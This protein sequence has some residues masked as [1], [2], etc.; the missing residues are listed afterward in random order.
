MTR[1][2]DKQPF[3]WAASS[4]SRT[5]SDDKKRSKDKNI[6]N[7]SVNDDFINQM[8]VLLFD[9]HSALLPINC[10]LLREIAVPLLL[11]KTN[12]T[13]SG[14]FDSSWFN[15]SKY[16]AY[17][18]APNNKSTGQRA[19]NM[20]YVGAMCLP[21]IIGWVVL[22]L[23]TYRPCKDKKDILKG[24]QAK[25]MLTPAFKAADAVHDKMDAQMA[26]LDKMFPM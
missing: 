13:K 26:C 1:L 14:S 6:P 23:S 17:D 16:K 9:D 15:G 21:V 11:D 24:V 7:R 12:Y 20:C 5:N 4:A 25:Y 10:D 8:G 19:V 3:L 22:A 18:N 2:T